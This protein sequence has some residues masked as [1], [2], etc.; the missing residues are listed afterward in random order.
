MLK[1]SYLASG[2]ASSD[3][4][5]L[6]LM[7]KSGQGMFQKIENNQKFIYSLD[8]TIKMMGRLYLLYDCN[9]IIIRKE[10]KWNSAQKV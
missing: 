1:M 3:Q 10:S 8:I 5:R 9:D 2:E 4:I 6:L 7:Q